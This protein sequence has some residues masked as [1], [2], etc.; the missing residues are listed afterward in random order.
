[1]SNKEYTQIKISGNNDFELYV[2]N[3]FIKQILAKLNSA[4]SDW[5]EPN[6]LSNLIAGK[7]VRKM[8]EKK[9]I[10][11]EELSTILQI[12]GVDI[13]IID[14][15]IEVSYRKPLEPREVLFCDIEGEELGNAINNRFFGAYRDQPVSELMGLPLDGYLT[16]PLILG[17]H[18]NQG[19]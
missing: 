11:E 14:Q 17:L 12:D 16:I 4:K 19:R 7:F 2:K 9:L 18:L 1:M 10:S 3:S 5:A 13:N 8:A 6:S 15:R